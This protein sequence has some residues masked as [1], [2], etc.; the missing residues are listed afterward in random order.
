MTKD[1]FYAILKLVSGEEIISKVCAFIENEEILIVL[2]HPITVNMMRVPNIN[3]T[4]K[5]GALDK[6]NR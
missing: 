3:S 6:F 5:G 2:D 4:Y 1:I